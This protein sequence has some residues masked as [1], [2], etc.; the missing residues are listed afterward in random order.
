M[1]ALAY[2]RTPNV[3]LIAL[4]DTFRLSS[5][6]TMDTACRAFIEVEGPGHAIFDFS[7]VLGID[8]ADSALRERARQ[9][10]LCPDFQRIVVAHHPTRRT[11]G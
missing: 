2:D 4:R 9:P 7:Q 1:F 6:Q 8:I 3:L 10:A 11:A 5:L